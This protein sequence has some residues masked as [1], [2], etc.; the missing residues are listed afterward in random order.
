MNSY[1]IKIV[2]IISVIILFITGAV[3]I[4][5]RNHLVLEQQVQ[6]VQIENTITL[7][8]EGL[9]SDKKVSI[10]TNQTVLEVLQ[11]IDAEDSR[12]NLI[13]KTYQDIGVLVTNIGGK[14][15]GEYGKYWRYT[16]NG[17][18]PLIAADALQLSG[19]EHIRWYF[20]E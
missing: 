13:T 1:C 3:V 15:N 12:V 19:G 6:N 14:E 18:T 20:D 8:L 9:F 10:T 16:V 7:S 2:T 4:T 11:Q 5:L 17:V